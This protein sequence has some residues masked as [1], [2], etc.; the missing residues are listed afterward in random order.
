MPRVLICAYTGHSSCGDEGIIDRL[1]RIT[2]KSST[3][4]T[5]NGEKVAKMHGARTVGR[6]DI[7]GIMREMMLSDLLILG[8]GTLLQRRTSTRSLLYYSAIAQAALAA[9]LPYVIYGGIDD[10]SPITKA[11]IRGAKELYLRDSHSMK[12]AK[13]MGAGGKCVF[14]PDP[15]L[16][17]I[18]RKREQTGDYLVCSPRFDDLRS[19]EAAAEYGK[20][21]RLKV[22]YAAM[23]PCDKGVCL[24]SAMRYGG[25]AVINDDYTKLEE[26]I[27]GARVV[28]SSRL[29]PCVIAYSG[30]VPFAAFSDD[31]KLKAFARDV[32]M[33]SACMSSGGADD[34]SKIAAGFDFDR[35]EQLRKYAYAGL[36][37]IRLSA[38][39]SH[40]R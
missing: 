26:L 10:D 40:G 4:I 13:S 28:L 33:E 37:G 27:K 25:S 2:G 24:R 6:Y 5:D 8:G 20:R 7:P 3:L 34:V 32:G 38:L 39:G 21:E 17:P 14:A 18:K 23:H 9:G 36:K 15:V 12:T 16:I 1:L 19:V 35:L 29:H 22:I 31:F 11:V 30:R